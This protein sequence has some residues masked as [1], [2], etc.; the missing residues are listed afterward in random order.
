MGNDVG[1]CVAG[2]LAKITWY[3]L[4]WQKFAV[5][6]DNKYVNINLGNDCGCL[7]VDS[8]VFYVFKYFIQVITLMNHIILFW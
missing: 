3:K 7:F 4:G 5:H 6:P 8:I 1:A 2:V